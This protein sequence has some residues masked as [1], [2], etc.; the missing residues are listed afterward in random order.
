MHMGMKNFLPAHLAA[1]PTYVVTVWREVLVHPVPYDRKESKSGDY[2]LF[3]Q[4]EYGFAMLNRD[5]HA[6]MF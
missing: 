1:I 3:A 2:L 5:N 4:V 6:G